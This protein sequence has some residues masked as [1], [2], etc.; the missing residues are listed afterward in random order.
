MKKYALRTTRRQPTRQQ[1]DLTTVQLADNQLADTPTRL[2]TNLPNFR[3]SEPF[4]S[5]HFHFIL[6]VK[7]YFQRS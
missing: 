3:L 1:T 4:F 2:Q 5:F 7:V 6:T